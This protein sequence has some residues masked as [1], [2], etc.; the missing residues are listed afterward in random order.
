MLTSFIIYARVYQAF[1]LQISQ[2][3][4]SDELW[5][6][7]DPWTDINEM[8]HAKQLIINRHVAFPRTQQRS[9]FNQIREWL[10][11]FRILVANLASN[12]LDSTCVEKHVA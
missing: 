4:L 12:T 3:K 7:G 10:N 5:H 2:L 1:S 9:M 6:V 11:W 8:F